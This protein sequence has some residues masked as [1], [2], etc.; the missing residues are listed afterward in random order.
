M[1]ST[2]ISLFLW[3]GKKFL[4]IRYFRYTLGFSGT[5]PHRIWGETCIWFGCWLLSSF[6]TAR[7]PQTLQARV[8]ILA[9]AV[10][11]QP[12]QLF[13]LPSEL[14]IKW[15]PGVTWERY[16]VNI[17]IVAVVVRPATGSVAKEREMSTAAMHS[18][19]YAPGFPFYYSIK[20]RQS[21]ICNLAP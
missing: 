21:N 8:Q 14:V 9:W 13:I 7:W 6:W 17:P 18:I 15:I 16:F 10:D 3:L 1:Y 20:H 4:Y 19:A 12:T 2:F 11:H 5:H